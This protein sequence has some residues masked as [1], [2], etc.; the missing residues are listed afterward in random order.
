VE[1]VSHKCYVA[2][3]LIV[4]EKARHDVARKALEESAGSKL[5]Q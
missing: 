1:G 3:R 5:A 2:Y 4:E